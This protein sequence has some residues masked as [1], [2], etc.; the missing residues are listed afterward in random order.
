MP[1]LDYTKILPVLFLEY[2]TISLARTLF[3]GM[4]NDEFGVYSY[5]AVGLMETV[6]GL[7]AFI[8]SPLFGKISDKIGRKFCLLLTVVGTTMPVWVMAFTS[9]MY[10]Y[11]VFMSISGFFSATFA[12][13]FAY[14]S[15]CVD[16]QKR[17][18]AYGLALATFGLSFSVGPVIGGYLAQEFG[19]HSVFVLSLGLT[20]VNVLYV[21]FIL[22][23]TVQSD[24]ASQSS[25][26][27]FG[28]AIK[29]LPNSWDLKETFR[30]FSSDPFMANLALIVFVYYSSVWAIVS[31][32][33]VYITRVLHFSAVSLGWLLSAYGIATMF[34]E[35]VLVR[36]VVPRVGETNAMRIGLVCFAL[37]CVVVGVCTSPEWIYLSVLFSLGANL[38]YPSVS[39]LVAKV[40]S[41]ELTGE[42]LGA[43]NG[44]R[45]LTEGFGPL[46]F[47][48][49]MSLFEHSPQPGAP[50]L[51]S[52]FL[53]LWA[54]LHCFELP[55]EP[56]VAFAKFH[57]RGS[58]APEEALSLLREEL[59]THDDS[60]VDSRWK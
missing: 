47:G 5:T 42:A 15:D 60:S 37:Q 55:P 46:F 50:Y 49:L 7:L 59:D 32:L 16:N 2:L 56:D 58:R 57:Q 23:E 29:N 40:V 12:I 52:A 3:P 48:F 17:A 45:A 30:V 34:S 24:D 33:M 4:I 8:S 44:I 35:G 25:Q 18:P 9:N 1:K 38:V 28:V 31:T 13:T 10:I 54:Y 20:V 27:K 21:V 14:I 53:S 41:E 22:P 26:A 36:V 51:L 11:A 43:L 6:K 39:S 19:N